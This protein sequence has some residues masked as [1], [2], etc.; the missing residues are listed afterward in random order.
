MHAWPSWRAPFSL[1]FFTAG[2]RR[3]PHGS[4]AT[5]EYEICLGRLTKM[6][7]L[8]LCTYGCIYL[9]DAY[10]HSSSSAG[11]SCTICWGEFGYTR[12]RCTRCLSMQN[13]FDTRGSG[14]NY[15]CDGIWANR[16][17]WTTRRLSHVITGPLNTLWFPNFRLHPHIAALRH[18][19]QRHLAF[20]LCSQGKMDLLQW[21]QTGPL[22]VPIPSARA[23]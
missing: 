20:G 13:Q 18:A 10:W 9:P 12:C 5:D 14:F 1:Y 7:G 15:V 3:L 17:P 21:E 4:Y 16:W 8:G 11:L 2:Q 23:N 19:V 6:L 22:G